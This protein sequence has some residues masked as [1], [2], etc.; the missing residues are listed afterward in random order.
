MMR[1]HVIIPAAGSGSRMGADAPKQYLSLN[2]KPLIQHVINVFDQAA[3]INSIHII[4][5]EGDV[6]WR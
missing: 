5:S 1:F 2:G 6:H 3:E 4:L